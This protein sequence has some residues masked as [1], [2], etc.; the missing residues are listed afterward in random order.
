M[1]FEVFSLG[2]RCASLHGVHKSLK[3]AA[4]C[5][6]EIL[7]HIDG[8]I[9]YNPVSQKYIH[10]IVK[11][12]ESGNQE[13]FSEHDKREAVRLN[14]DPK[15]FVPKVPGIITFSYL[16]D[17]YYEACRWMPISN[18]SIEGIFSPES[19]DRM[20]WSTEAGQGQALAYAH[21][22]IFTLELSLKAVLEVLG[23]LK[24]ENKRGRNGWTTHNLILLFNFLDKDEHMELEKWW[25]HREDKTEYGG[26]LLQFLNEYNDLDVQWRYLTEQKTFDI[27]LDIRRLLMGAAF[28]IGASSRLWRERSPWRP[29]VTARIVHEGGTGE[30]E[31]RFFRTAVVGK[32]L[33]IDVPAGYD[34]HSFVE[35]VV[36]DNQE[37]KTTQVRLP[38]RN[39]EEY[40]DLKAG[41]SVCI[42]GCGTDYE[43]NVLYF[44]NYIDG[45]PARGNYSVTLR[46]LRGFVYDLRQSIPAFGVSSKVV[47]SLYDET[48]FCLVDCLFVSNSEKELL[49]GL[50]LSDKILVSGKVAS[51]DGKPITVFNPVSIEETEYNSLHLD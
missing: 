51:R 30:E 19:R 23:K 47:L 26:T 22:A 50:K 7:A 6:Y 25:V 40:F 37:N 16:A 35:I 49:S 31:R 28:L 29:K 41:D 39:I 46:T 32:V 38:R 17:L 18:L 45:S 2:Y 14:L 27:S 8:Q 36:N 20:F 1:P 44:E 33:E 11:V 5:L 24:E 13:G 43:P 15:S 48:Y 34:P 10:T 42:A 3:E 12:D 4:D 9:P 21:Q